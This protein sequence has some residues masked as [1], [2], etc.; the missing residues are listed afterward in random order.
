MSFTF[1]I[2]ASGCFLSNLL[3]CCSADFK[4]L[5]SMASNKMVYKKLN[6]N[7]TYEYNCRKKNLSNKEEYRKLVEFFVRLH[8]R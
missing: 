4:L 6:S 1:R 2:S 8:Q 7:F 3:H 5:L